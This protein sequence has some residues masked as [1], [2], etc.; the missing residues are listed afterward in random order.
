MKPFTSFFV[1]GL[2]LAQVGAALP[3]RAQSTSEESAMPEAQQAHQHFNL[4]VRLHAEGDFGPALAQFERAYALKP[5]FRVLYNIAQCHFELRDYVQARAALTRYLVDG[6]GALDAERR[7]RV[8]ADLADMVRRIAQ[9]DIHSNVRGAAVYMDG[10]KVG[11]TPLSQPIEVSEGQRSL[12]VESGARGTKQRTIVLVGGERQ[13]ITVNFE[14]IAPE[15]AASYGLEKSPLRPRLPS[16]SA[17]LGA[18]FWVAGV[19]AVL[20]GA[21]AGATGYLALRAQ[22]ERRADLDRPNVAVELDA[23]KRRIRTLAMTSDALLGSAIICA[24]VATTLLVVHG[25][26]T[27]PALAVGPA[28]VALRGSF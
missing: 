25:T 4:G 10:R 17:G 9:I 8:E 15:P 22:D 16:S 28:N 21:G 24:G 5:H 14:P 3:A 7:A 13:A 11:T 20:L 23:D 2:L 19:G 26:E 18:G 27:S 6:A 12:S 1:V